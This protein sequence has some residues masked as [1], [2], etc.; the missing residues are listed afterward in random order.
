M[1]NITN[2]QLYDLAAETLAQVEEE[3]SDDT[4]PRPVQATYGLLQTAVKRHDMDAI[5]YHTHELGQWIAN[6]QESV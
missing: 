3:W 1:S 4:M 5:Y 6:N 2:D